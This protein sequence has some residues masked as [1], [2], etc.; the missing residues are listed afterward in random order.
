MWNPSSGPRGAILGSSISPRSSSSS[1]TW[2][3]CSSTRGPTFRQL[4]LFGFVDGRT[5]LV[6]AIGFVYVWR[7]GAL[8][9]A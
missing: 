9:R 5:V 2:R 3:S 6:L 1:S 8:D 4:G 7:K